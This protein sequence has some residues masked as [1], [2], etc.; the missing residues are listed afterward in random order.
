MPYRYEPYPMTKSIENKLLEVSEILKKISEDTNFKFC[1]SVNSLFNWKL[2][3]ALAN[4]SELLATVSHLKIPVYEEMKEPEK[5]EALRWMTKGGDI[6]ITRGHT[7]DECYKIANEVYS[8]AFKNRIQA[9][10]QRGFITD[11]YAFIRNMQMEGITMENGTMTQFI[12][13]MQQEFMLDIARISLGFKPGILGCA[14]GDLIN[15]DLSSMTKEK[16]NEFIMNATEDDRIF[17]ILKKKMEW[18]LPDKENIQQPWL[19]MMVSVNSCGNPGMC[20]IILKAFLESVKKNNP[21][22]P[23]C[24]VEIT[25]YTWDDVYRDYPPNI[26]DPRNSDKYEKMWDAQKGQDANG[27]SYN[28]VDTKEYWEELFV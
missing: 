17:Q 15:I 22:T 12:D 3:E 16:A 2:N 26:K 8:F 19:L 25:P 23:L 28:K 27:H 6:I 4:V 18:A 9:Y 7:I 1:P 21:D 5:T 11:D 10:D 24:Q 20:Q 13:S 14:F